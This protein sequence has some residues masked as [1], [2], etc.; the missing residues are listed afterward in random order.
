MKTLLSR[1]GIV[2][3][4]AVVVAF[5]VQPVAAERIW[6]EAASGERGHGW[7]FGSSGRNPGACWIVTAGHIVRDPFTKEPAAFA[8]VDQHGVS[9]E[10]KKP[11][12]PPGVGTTGEAA[13]PDDLVFA[14]VAFGREHGRCLSRLGLNGLAYD[15]VLRSSPKLTLY[16]LL[17]TSFGTFTAHVERGG[18]ADAGGQLALKPTTRDED[19]HLK[20]GLSGAIAEVEVNG[21]PEP[22]A[23]V[24][25][26]VPDKSEMRALRFDL[27]RSAFARMEAALGET[28]AEAV[29]THAFDIVSLEGATTEGSP[30]A[31]QDAAFTCWRARPRSDQ[32]SVRLVISLAEGGQAPQWLRLGQSGDC[33]TEGASVS[34]DARVDDRASWSRLSD[35]RLGDAGYECRLGLRGPRQLR[36]SVYGTEEVGISS[37]QLR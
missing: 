12:A 30:A 16:D 23:M 17:P 4:A 35:C 3:A 5:L 37:L 34:I 2:G 11:I 20:R 29:E 14:E 6:I 32:R 24:Q 18:L 27:I 28:D 31:L 15:T 13:G 33:R 25:D 9:G 19:V 1:F 22:F 7:L 8:F 10:S 36:I 26:V 21:A